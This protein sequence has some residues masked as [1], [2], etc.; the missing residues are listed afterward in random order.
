MHYIVFNGKQLER[1]FDA[2]HKKP[3][4][5]FLPLFKV[6][7]LASDEINRLHPAK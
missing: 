3:G 6:I 2:I 1:A 5:E 7:V 4:Y